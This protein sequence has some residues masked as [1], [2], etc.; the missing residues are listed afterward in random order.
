[1]PVAKLSISLSLELDKAIDT[2]ARFDGRPKSTVIEML[3]RENKSVSGVIHVQR[4]GEPED[5]GIRPSREFWARVEKGRAAKAAAQK[6]IV[7]P[8]PDPREAARREQSRASHTKRVIA[9]R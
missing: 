5:F 2:I 3:L 8:T 7:P 1:V 6:E 9:G 4:G